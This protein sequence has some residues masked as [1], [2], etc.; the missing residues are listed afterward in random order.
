M[1]D[2]KLRLSIK[3]TFSHPF[4]ILLIGAAISGLLVPYI[5]NQW[6]NHQKELELKTG[7]ASQIAKAV[8]NI[9]IVSRIV[10]IPAYAYTNLSYAS[11]FEEWEISKATIGSQ[12]EAYFP[13]TP[14]KQQWDNLSSAI[15]D[16]SSLSPQLTQN[17]TSHSDYASKLCA[18]IGH[19]LNLH[20]YLDHSHPINI[21]YNELN[22]Y[23]CQGIANQKQ[24]EKYSPHSYNVDWRVLVYKNIYPSTVYF[25][26]WHMLEEEL[27]NEKD[28]LIRTILNTHISVF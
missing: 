5:T 19:V 24:L 11:T 23:G 28:N 22:I 3:N 27:Q 14:I 6:Q 4:I 18:R 26:N 21:N 25:K 10:Q 15:T 2:K 7:L 1:I 13:E 12:I 8:A 9:I 17:H 20:E 16:L